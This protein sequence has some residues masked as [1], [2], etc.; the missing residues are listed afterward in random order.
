L[1][2]TILLQVALLAMQMSYQDFHWSYVY[3]L[4][5]PAPPYIYQPNDWA[6]GEYIASYGAAWSQS[7]YPR[8]ATVE[9]TYPS[10]TKT[11][12]PSPAQSHVPELG[13]YTAHTASLSALA[14]AA[15]FVGQVQT[16][17]PYPSSDV[18]SVTPDTLTRVHGSPEEQD[19]RASREK[20]HPCTMCHKR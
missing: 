2:D 8:P 1:P 12:V 9:F 5:S 16:H 17:T 14:D 18:T 11:S 7:R 20:R 19:G 4:S 13:Y 15:I 10:T 6:D 3:A